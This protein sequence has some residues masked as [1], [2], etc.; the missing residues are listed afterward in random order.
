MNTHRVAVLVLP[1]VVPLDLAIPTQ[2]FAEEGGMPY[3]LT[4]CGTEPGPVQTTAGYAVQV[5]AGLAAAARADTI[6]VPGYQPHLRQ[7]PPAVCRLLTRAHERGKRI[8]SI[9]TGAFAL[10]AA[11]VLDGR[12]A[13]THWIAADELAE[14]YPRVRVDPDVLY[15]DEGTVL[16]SAGIAAGIDL[17]LHIIRCDLG[18]RTA[19]RVARA[20]VAAPHRT[21]G[22]AQYIR[23][24]PPREAGTSLA[25]TLAWA[26][27]RLHEPLTVADLAAHAH[28]SPRTLAR[29]FLAE[30]GTSPLRWLLTARIDL[31]RQLLESGDL[32]IT[33]IAHSCGF[34]SGPNLRKHFHRLVG[35]S[36]TAYR[37]SFAFTATDPASSGSATAPG[38]AGAL[39]AVRVR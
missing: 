12:T 15:V 30:T 25:D 11:G 7:V 31:A 32:G 33:Q 13:T 21:G 18:A 1:D 19:D 35:T 39:E 10:A 3:R 17:C 27:Q 34:G 22:Q 9:C 16:T 4:L 20:I 28:V 6:V 14:H 2:I 38:S 5:G 29:R 23:R 8:V 36:P 26:R 37:Q 24:P